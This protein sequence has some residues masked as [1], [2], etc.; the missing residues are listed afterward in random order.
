MDQQL[1]GQAALPE[2]PIRFPAPVQRLTTSCNS[3]ERGS[4]AFFWPLRVPGTQVQ[5]VVEEDGHRCEG[6]FSCS[7]VWAL[8]GVAR[9][10]GVQQGFPLQG[11]SCLAKTAKR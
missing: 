7:L 4:R 3:S 1:S 5:G 11:H 8:V 10:L 2:N 9:E 6:V